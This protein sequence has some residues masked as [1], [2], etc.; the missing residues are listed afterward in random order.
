MTH[1]NYGAILRTKKIISWEHTIETFMQHLHQ[2]TSYD[3][4]VKTTKYDGY[5]NIF[6]TTAR[7]G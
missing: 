2:F 1:H 5:V 7:D 3:C 4:I 6:A